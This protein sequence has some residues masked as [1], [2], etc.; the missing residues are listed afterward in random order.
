MT[1]AWLTDS[2]FHHGKHK[3]ARYSGHYHRNLPLGICLVMWGAAKSESRFTELDLKKKLGW[4]YL[5]TL[6]SKFLILDNKSELRSDVSPRVKSSIITYRLMKLA[7]DT[8]FTCTRTGISQLPSTMPSF[9]FWEPGWHLKPNQQEPVPN[10]N[11]IS[12]PSGPVIKFTDWLFLGTPFTSFT[13]LDIAPTLGGSKR[14]RKCLTSVSLD[15]LRTNDV[16]QNQW[17]FQEAVVI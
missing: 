4:C 8:V 5:A 7:P 15:H 6:K 14:I 2:K 3:T 10:G 16:S 1:D 11:F 9:T 12:C 17:F 13:T